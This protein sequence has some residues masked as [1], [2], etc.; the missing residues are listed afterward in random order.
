LLLIHEGRYLTWL[1]S[2]VVAD[3]PDAITLRLWD[4]KLE[5]VD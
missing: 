4:D 2:D 3:R 1:E 5:S